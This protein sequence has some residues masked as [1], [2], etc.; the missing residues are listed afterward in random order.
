[1][2]KTVKETTKKQKNN[3]RIIEAI[4]N[5]KQEENNTMNN[6][7]QET[8]NTNINTNTNKENNDM[9]NNNN[10]NNIGFFTRIKNAI[11]AG[12]NKTVEEAK[13]DAQIVKET[14]TNTLNENQDKN[15]IVRHSK[16][17]WAVT[18]KCIWEPICMLS[19]A[20]CNTVKGWFTKKEEAKS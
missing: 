12:W 16:A 20:L 3:N 8:I 13:R 4:I 1:M 17:V 6:N 7:T 18:K 15:V 5:H 11:K 2:E 19:R 14:Y 10:N 9:E